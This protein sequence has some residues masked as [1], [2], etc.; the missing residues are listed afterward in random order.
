MYDKPISHSSR[1]L[2]RK[3]PKQWH[4]KYIL[5]NRTESGPAAARGTDIHGELEKFFKEKLPLSNPVFQPWRRAL[6]ALT[7]RQVLAE[8]E[9]A[10]NAEWEE[11]TFDAP[12]AYFR[13][14]VDLSYMLG[15]T[16]VIIDWKTGRVYKDHQEQGEDYIALAPEA[17]RYQTEFWYIDSPQL[18]AINK[19]TK[20][21]RPKF[22]KRVKEE[23]E[24]IRA[25]TEFKA[26]PSD[27]NCRFCPLSW[28]NG[29]KCEAAP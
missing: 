10:R 11:T 21:D 7:V 28:R 24:A 16:L 27:F 12:D 9:L 19:Y 5:G 18:V 20:K 2:F 15:N 14:K 26:T 13:G 3:C 23:V 4:D 17:E 29:G 25:E 1:K 8:Q 6:E 22:V